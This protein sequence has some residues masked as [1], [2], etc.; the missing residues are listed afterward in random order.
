MRT[1]TVF[2]ILGSLLLFLSISFIVPIPF[3]IYFGDGR[4]GVFILS[5]IITAIAGG[6]LRYIFIPQGEMGHR[7]GFAVVTFGWLGLA[8]FG[9]LPFYL[10][11]SAFTG[12]R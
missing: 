6:L 12:R 9:A 1:S 4:V 2:H 11:R 10:G 7:G 3:S 5:A 8:L